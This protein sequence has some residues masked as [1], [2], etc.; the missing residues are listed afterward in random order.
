MWFMSPTLIHACFAWFKIICDHHLRYVGLVTRIELCDSNC[1]FV[2][3]WD[4]VDFNQD[5]ASACTFWWKE[6]LART[7]TSSL[8]FCRQVLRSELV[9]I[10]LYLVQVQWVT[11]VQ[12]LLVLFSSLAQLLLSVI[13]IASCFTSYLS[14]PCCNYDD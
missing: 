2:T 9:R 13:Q 3:F 1:E 12:A 11:L 6:I 5:S 10:C 8:Q 7:I 4:W 14:Q